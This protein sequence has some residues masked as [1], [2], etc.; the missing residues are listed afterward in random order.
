LIEDRVLRNTLAQGAARRR[1]TLCVP[2]VEMPKMALLLERIASS[3]Y[4]LANG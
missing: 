1:K 4:E 3:S 2:S